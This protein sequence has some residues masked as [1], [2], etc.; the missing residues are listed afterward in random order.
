MRAGDWKLYLPLKAKHG[1]GAA[2][3]T[4][5]PQALELYD[6]RHDVSEQQEVSAQHPDI[7]ARLTALAE[8]ARAEL[9]DGDQQG[10]GQRP[11]GHVENPQPL[12]P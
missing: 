10:T 8:K 11:P 5:P 4:P 6:V 2:K 7:V 3:K 9:G 12:V 1:L